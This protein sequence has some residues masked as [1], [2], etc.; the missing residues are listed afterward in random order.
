M[1]WAVCVSKTHRDRTNFWAVS[2]YFIK[3]EKIA[4]KVLTSGVVSGNLTKLSDTAARGD[5]GKTSGNEKIP[6]ETP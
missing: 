1:A 2:R 3:R 5:R 6:K 4:K